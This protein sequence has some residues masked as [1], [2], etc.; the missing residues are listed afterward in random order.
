MPP[1]PCRGGSGVAGK[2]L[3]Q[4]IRKRL[5]WRSQFHSP[6]KPSLP[7]CG[8]VPAA[9]AVAAGWGRP[10]SG[11]EPAPPACGPGS[12]IGRGEPSQGWG[13]QDTCNAGMLRRWTS[14]KCHASHGGSRGPCTE[15]AAL[16]SQLRLH[17]CGQRA[18]QVLWH[19]KLAH[20]APLQPV[21]HLHPVNVLPQLSGC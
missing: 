3:I 7:T 12:H 10:G 1:G 11:A 4:L 19:A 8:T 2:G 21:R 15:A 17:R 5:P 14:L 16:R 6:T 13:L 9:S 20:H 18:H